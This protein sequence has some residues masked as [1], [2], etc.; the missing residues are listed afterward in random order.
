VKPDRGEIDGGQHDPAS[1]QD[2][3]RRRF[4]EAEGY[5]VVGFWHNQMLHNPESVSV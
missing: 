5:R 2:V 1:T 3:E 4:L